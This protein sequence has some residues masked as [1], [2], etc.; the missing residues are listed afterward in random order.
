MAEEKDG[1]EFAARVH[2]AFQEEGENEIFKKGQYLTREG[3]VERR[4]FFIE[5]GAVKIYFLSEMGEKIIRLGYDGSILNSLSSF[6]TQ[7]PSDLYIEAIRETK[8]K[9]LTKGKVL[10][11][12]ANST[13][14]PQFLESLLIQQLERELDLLHDS[15]SLRLER[16]L[17]RSPHLFQHIPLKYIASYLRMSPETLS[18]IRKA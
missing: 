16:V 14:Y 8:V 6:F 3:E 12:I 2:L 13:Q 18:R 7:A 4:L 5:S 15:P 11:L 9:Y 17:A 10:E 1:S